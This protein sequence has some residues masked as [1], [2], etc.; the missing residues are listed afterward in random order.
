MEYGPEDI[1]AWCDTILPTLYNPG[2][3]DDEEI[4][5]DVW[6]ML[7]Q[8]ASELGPEKEA[9][10]DAAADWFRQHRELEVD[11]LQTLTEAQI[12]AILD[13]PQ[14]VQ[15]SADWYT[16][17]R[18]RLTASEFS[19]VLT[20][21]R[22]RLL[23]TKLDTTS[24]DRPLQSP[25]ALAQADGEMIATSW[26]HRFEPIVRSIY[27]L[28]LAGPNTVCDTLGR[29]THRTYPWLSASP[30]GIV[31]KGPLAGRLREIKAPKNRQPDTYVPSEYYVQ[32]QIQMEVCDLEAVDFVEAQ[33]GQQVMYSINQQ[34][35]EDFLDIE[36]LPP[37][38]WYGM[39]AV[40]GDL[41]T[42]STW[43][44]KYG[45]PAESIEDLMQPE[46][47]DQ[48]LLEVAVWYLKGWYPRT[49]LRNP[50][51]WGSVGQPAAELFWAEVLSRRESIQDTI[52]IHDSEDS[53][54]GWLGS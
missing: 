15:H 11:S 43:S 10:L 24:Q 51:W 33:F 32:M 17:R 14:T 21:S 46:P 18:N 50:N 20:G 2:L 53:V 30:D 48:P 41:D 40:Y 34:D 35:Q 1:A 49:V 12:K 28:E 9:L 54:A 7:E 45:E 16:Q 8:E 52:D 44:Y 42:P 3:F 29:F 36:K 37:A 23:K 6:N 22:E 25:V 38:K 26:G 4:T 19:N 27:E 5:N 13:T 47:S 39:I 31:T